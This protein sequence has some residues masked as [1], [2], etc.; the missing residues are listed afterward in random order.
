MISIK[1]LKFKCGVCLFVFIPTDT[2]RGF[3][4]FCPPLGSPDERFKVTVMGSLSPPIGGC[5]SMQKFRRNEIPGFNLWLGDLQT[6]SGNCDD[7]DLDY[8]MFQCLSKNSF[9]DENENIKGWY[10]TLFDPAGRWS[11]QAAHKCSLYS[12]IKE[13]PPIIQMVISANRS[14][15]GLARR[16]GEVEKH[17]VPEGLRHFEDGSVA[18]LFT[19]N[20]PQTTSD[21]YDDDYRKKRSAVLDSVHR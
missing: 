16:M 1:Y 13:D 12:L 14:C 8:Y 2:L 15:D 21:M 4:K 5:A 11:G 18:L 17:R 7:E 10:V 20:W 6:G 3:Q 19:K 9:M